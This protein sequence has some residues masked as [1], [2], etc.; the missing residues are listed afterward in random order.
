MGI[1]EGLKR[2][3]S[4]ERRLKYPRFVQEYIFGNDALFFMI[5]LIIAIITATTVYLGV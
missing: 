1:K 3:L 5:I 4:T 2:L